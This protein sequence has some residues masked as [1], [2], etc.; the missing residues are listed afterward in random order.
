MAA[1][2]DLI[3]KPKGKHIQFDGNGI[4]VPDHVVIPFI[5]G[6]GIGV[7]ITP[8][9]K[10]VTDHAVEKAYGGQKVIDWLEIYAGQKAYDAY[11]RIGFLPRHKPHSKGLM[12]V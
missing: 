9:M 11:P 8:Q 7:D 5:E 1:Y 12:V 2:S 4:Q 6:D 3:K 10:R